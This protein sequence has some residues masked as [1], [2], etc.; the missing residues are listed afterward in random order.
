MLD[1]LIRR[2][3]SEPLV[4]VSGLPR[5]GTSM[6]M[7]MLGAGGLSLLTD[8]TRA[9]DASNPSGYF[10]LESVTRLDAAAA[11][12]LVAAGRGKAVKIVSPL[13]H[14]LPDPGPYRVVF[15]RRDLDEVLDSQDRM[16]ARRGEAVVDGESA[17]LRPRFEQHLEDVRAM[18]A[19]RPCFDTLEVEH[20]DVLR[21]PRAAA[22]RVARFLGTP[23]DVDRMA[24]AVNPALHRSRR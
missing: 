4:V 2:R 22:G 15:M 14:H 20:R 19:R 13:L 5:S 17:G 8:G 24:A 3:T 11:R 10:E 1:R 18:L 9:A 21:D 16:L 6:M 23:L 7:Q 12:A